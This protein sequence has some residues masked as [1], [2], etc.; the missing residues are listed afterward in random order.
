MDYRNVFNKKKAEQFPKPQPWDHAINLKPDFVPKDCKVYPLTPQEHM[1]MDKFINE[2]LAKGYIRPSKSPMASPFFFVAKKSGDLRPCQDYWR[3]NEGTIKNSYPLPL[4]SDLVDQLKGAKYFTKLDI[5]WEYNNVRIKDGDQWKAAFKTSWGLFEPT[6]M[7]F[8][9][10]NSPATLQAMMDNVFQDM[11][12]EGWIIIYM[13]DIFIFTKELQQNIKYIKQ[14]LQQLQD[15]NLYLKPEKCTS[16]TTKVE[17]L[18]LIIQENLISMDPVKLNGIKDWPTPTT[19]KQVR[20]F[21]GFGNYYRQFIQGYGN[22]TWPLNDLSRKDE[23]FEWTP[24]RQDAFD[25]LK[26]CFTKSPVLLMPDSLKPFVLEMDNSLF[27]SGAVLQQQDSNGDW[28][29]CAYL[30]KSFN[31]MEHNY[32]IWDRELLAVIRALTKWWHYLQGSLHTVTLLSDH[33]NLAYFRKLQWLNWWQARWSLLL[34]EYNLKLMHVPG[35]KMIQSD[36]LSQQP[37]L[38]P[39]ITRTMLTKPFYRMASLSAPSHLAKKNLQM[40]LNEPCYW[41]T[42][43]WTPLIWTFILRSL[44]AQTRTVWYWMP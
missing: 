16:W 2:N 19:V 42:Y 39:K 3:L 27:A 4:I 43:F 20:S 12:T 35:T 37:D 5:R 21:L 13:D 40:Q 22:L 33:Q 10:C 29:P 11:K 31:D 23:R 17:Y 32:D 28:H 34:T 14:T 15:N 26:Q 38:C 6:V 7:F 9:M 25:T 44:P 8:G 30:S 18:G 41:T 24:E 36:A 1:E